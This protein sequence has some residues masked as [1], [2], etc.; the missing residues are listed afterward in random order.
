MRKLAAFEFL[1]VRRASCANS[2]S[3]MGTSYGTA[4]NAI[5]ISVKVA[6]KDG[7]VTLQRVLKALDLVTKDEAKRRHESIDYRGSVINL[8]LEA[9]ASSFFLD[10]LLECGI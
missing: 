3:R 8:S 1:D 4:K 7:V 5:A 10:D 6:G 9:T 2:Y